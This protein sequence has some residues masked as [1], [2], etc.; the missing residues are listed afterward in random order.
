MEGIMEQVGILQE[1]VSSLQMLNHFLLT[2]FMLV[3]MIL[4]SRTVVAGTRYSPILLIVIF[5]LA[6][7]FILESSGVATPGLGEFPVIEFLSK[8]TNIALIVTFFVGGQEIRKIFGDKELSNAELLIPSEEEVVLGTTR[9][10][11]VFIIRSFFLLLGIE[12]VSRLILGLNSSPLGDYYAILAYLG[13]VGA[14]ILIDNKAT[15]TDKRMYIKKGALEIAVIIGV[16]LITYYLSSAIQDLVALPQIFFAMIIATAIGALFYSYSFGPTIKALLFAGIPVVLAGNFMVGGSR[17]MEAFAMEDANAVLGYGFF[18][19]I[20]WMFGGIALLIYVAGTANV[21]NLAPGMAGAL[22][23][24]GL[25]GA[26][27]AGDLGAKAANRAPMLVNIPFAMHIFVFSILAMSSDR[28]ALLMIPSIILMILGVVLL[29]MGLKNLKRCN[30][31]NDREEVK[32]LLQFGFGWQ[33]IAIFGGLIALSF[34][35]MSLEFSAMAK[36]SAISHF[37]LFAAIQEGMFGPEAAGLVTFTFSMTFL[38]H[39]FVFYMF[40]KA[41]ENDGNMPKLPVYILTVVGLMGL[42]ISIIFL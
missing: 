32:G 31:M 37:G 25:T 10:Q 27:T 2:L 24:T 4:I 12:A 16:S 17:I 39:P 21:R 20:F 22:S 6:M 40:G 30:G 14:I 18:G 35:S 15:Y 11:L 9:T 41:M 34:S 23:H 19:Q 1:Q 33:L 3:P 13:L 29:V 26:C 42:I 8:T 5:G 7:G 28:G 36:A 38:I